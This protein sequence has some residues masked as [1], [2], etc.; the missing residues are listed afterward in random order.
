M[1][2]TER[3]KFQ[4]TE[5]TSSKERLKSCIHFSFQEVSESSSESSL[6]EIGNL[7]KSFGG[8]HAVRNLN[9]EIR[10]GEIVGFIGPNGA[11]KTTVCNL[12]SGLLRPD[13]GFI[14]FKG[15]I[16]SGLTPHAICLKGIGRT[17]QIVQIFQKMT[18]QDNLTVAGFSRLKKIK[19]IKDQSH[20]ILG[21]L[22][23]EHLKEEYAA[24]ISGGQQ[25]LLEF[26]RALM[27]NPELFILDE[28]FV[29]V[30]PKIRMQI[31]ELIEMIHST[32]KTFIVI[33]H[34]MKSIFRLSN[35]L[36]VLSSGTK[37]ADGP[38]SEIR[39]DE[40][41]LKAYLGD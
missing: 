23:L 9:L 20:E 7:S 12:V 16:I 26:G 11:G 39:H 14:K 24:N 40:T 4:E 36:I 33:S 19:A 8:L 32:G 5:N 21:I 29:G 1:A 25:K 15:E 41:V 10:K 34:D 31:Y 2:I 6:I 3:E 35:R 17:F 38:P 18:V 37:I 30:H 22:N 28:P 27:L 13:S